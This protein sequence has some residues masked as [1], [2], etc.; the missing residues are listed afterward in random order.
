MLSQQE[1]DA[2]VLL[3]QVEAARGHREEALRILRPF[4][5]NYQTG[6]I[7]LSDFAGVYAA[8]G[9]EPNT[10]KWLERSMDAREM[11][12]I[13]IHIDPVYAR[14]QN[15]PAFHR[16]KKRRVSPSQA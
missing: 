7:L 16:L 2:A 12:A 3:A 5:S 15:T 9:D 8:M 11:P 1:P 13:Y 6:K 14:M 10:V 4:E